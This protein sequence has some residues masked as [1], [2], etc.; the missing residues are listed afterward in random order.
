MNSRDICGNIAQANPNLHSLPT[1]SGKCRKHQMEQQW[2]FT[3]N[4]EKTTKLHE[5]NIRINPKDELA[6][7]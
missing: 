2:N 6:N 5:K 3:I 1:E 4:K 7:K